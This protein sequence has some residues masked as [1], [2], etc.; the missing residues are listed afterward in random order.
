MIKK[1]D[2]CFY[3][4]LILTADIPKLTLKTDSQWYSSLV[5]NKKFTVITA[6]ITQKHELLKYLTQ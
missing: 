5:H 4:S 2:I 1:T 6:K 3:T